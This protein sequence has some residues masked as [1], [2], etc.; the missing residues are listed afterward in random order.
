MQ[1]AELP[2]KVPLYRGPQLHLQ[3]GTGGQGSSRSPFHTALGTLFR[4]CLPWWR[5]RKRTSRDGMGLRREGVVT[6]EGRQ[7]L[8]AQRP[9]RW[10]KDMGG[11]KAGLS[12]W[13]LFWVFCRA[14]PPWI[15]RA[16]RITWRAV[17]VG[18]GVWT[19]WHIHDRCLLRKIQ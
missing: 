3:M 18:R 9:E 16:A 10:E 14:G 1:L 13:H 6:E 2:D 12:W 15:S 8:W 11:G 19:N 5:G 4:D 7:H 17:G